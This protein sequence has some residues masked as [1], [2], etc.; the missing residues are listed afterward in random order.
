MNIKHNFTS[1]FKSFK[2]A[3][4]GLIYCLKNE[5][6]MRF[7]FC[8]AFYVLMFIRFYDLSSAQKAAVYLTIGLVISLEAVNTAIEAAVDLSANGIKPSAKI[9]KDCAAGAVLAAAIAA[10]FV[11]VSVF[12][13]L[14]TLRKLGRYLSD[15]SFA[16][17]QLIVSVLLSL[18]VIF[19]P[20]GNKRKENM[21]E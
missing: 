5:R 18:T 6:N 7:H 16:M 4:S 15:N 21:N 20:K 17:V 1:F 14:D 3:F 11:G 8:A 12:W 19:L 9:A 2:Y 13:D 10:I